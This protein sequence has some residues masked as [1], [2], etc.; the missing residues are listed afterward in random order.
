MTLLLLTGC[1]SSMSGSTMD[2]KALSD[3]FK[4][5]PK[6]DAAIATAVAVQS[7]TAPREAYGT[8]TFG[9]GA[10]GVSDPALGKE[11]FE[12]T[13]VKLYISQVPSG[14]TPG[15]SMGEIEL[16]DPLGRKALFLYNAEYRMDGDQITLTSLKVA[17]NYVAAPRTDF[18]IVRAKDLPAEPIKDYVSLIRFLANKGI[19]PAEYK[20]LGAQEFAFFA[21]AR[22]WAGP[23]AKM[24]IGMSASKTGLSGHTQGSMFSRVDKKWP[25]AVTIG[26]LDPSNAKNPLYAK[27]TYRAQGGFTAS[28]LLGVYQLAAFGK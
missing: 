22:D 11:K 26:T 1:I 13:G 7:A 9:K 12:F 27:I 10:Q 3:T 25:M 24:E 8:V 20:T 21:V 19:P 5:L 16:T 18:T 15:Q 28:K 6:E 14:S 23:E 4:A 17:K 2:V